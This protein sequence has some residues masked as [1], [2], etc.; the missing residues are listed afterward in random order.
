[1]IV[2]WL[3]VGI[4]SAH[5]SEMFTRYKKKNK[6]TMSAVHLLPLHHKR[7]G[8]LGGSGVEAVVELVACRCKHS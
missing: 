1:M 2:A 7:S 4:R 8:C 5:A 6:K 3:L